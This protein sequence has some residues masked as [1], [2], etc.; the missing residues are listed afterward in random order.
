MGFGNIM[1]TSAAGMAAQGNRL[2]TVADN[3]ANIATNGYKSASVEF[4]T[5]VLDQ[6]TGLT[7]GGG[8]YTSGGVAS[9]VRYAIEQQGGFRYTT[10]STD[11]AIQGD[12]FFVVSAPDGGRFLTRAGSFTPNGDGELVNAAGY[13]LLGYALNGGGAVA[14]SSVTGLVPVNI[15]GLALSASPTTSGMFTANLPALATGVSS[16][17]LPSANSATAVYTAKSSLLAYGNLGEPVTLDVYA[18]KTGPN[19][20]EYAVFDR[21]AAASGGGFPY[22]S[23]AL[24]TTT[25]DFDP[26]NGGLAATSPTSLVIP[27][28]GGATASVSIAGTTQLASDF[29][30]RSADLDGHAPSG[31]DNVSIADDGTLSVVYGNGLSTPAWRIPLGQVTSPNNLQPLAGNV[32]VATEGSGAIRVSDATTGSAGRISA[33]ALEES[34]VDI[35]AELTTMIEAQRNYSANSKVFQTGAELMDVLI[36]LRV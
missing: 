1:M 27:V 26:L 10:S 8:D 9:H 21:A 19:T 22:S 33:S 23:P 15:N 5:L 29:V 31:I 6:A 4:S 35:S 36:N 2:G 7:F 3:I 11:L 13:S 30:I 34:N 17:D 16:P 32:F 14:P 28:P 12:G 24:A 20:W 18:T 25:L